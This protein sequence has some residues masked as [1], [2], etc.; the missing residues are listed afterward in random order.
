MRKCSRLVRYGP[1]RELLAWA[2]GENS[3]HVLNQAATMTLTGH[4]DYVS[5]LDF[6]SKER[7]LASGSDDHS[8]RVWDLITGEAVAVLIGHADWIR[9][10]DYT[11][12]GGL[13][14]GSLDGT[15][16]KW[17]IMPA[18]GQGVRVHY[19]EEAEWIVERAHEGDLFDLAQVT[20]RGDTKRRRDWELRCERG[21]G[22]CSE[23]V[24]FQLWRAF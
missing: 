9:A 19:S 3:I 23:G 15:I 1:R 6:D 22:W 12:D 17:N 20:L 2:D 24:E 21:G 18:E 10:V 7:Y 16:I 11:P 4:T 5:V 13:V 8:V 14:S